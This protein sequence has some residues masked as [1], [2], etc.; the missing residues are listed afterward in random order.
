MGRKK[1]Y[2]YDDIARELKDYPGDLRQYCIE[3]GYNYSSIRQTIR[4]DKNTKNIL[5][6][7]KQDGYRETIV[8]QSFNLGK[9][10]AK[11]ITALQAKQ[12]ESVEHVQGSMDLI[13]EFNHGILITTLNLLHHKNEEMKNVTKP[14]KQ[15][16]LILYNLI[17]TLK[18]QFEIVKDSAL[19]VSRLSSAT[20]NLA[21][22][23]QENIEIKREMYKR[24]QQYTDQAENLLSRY[25]YKMYDDG[26]EIGYV[27]KDKDGS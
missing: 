26:R 9:S 27:G 23:L 4:G 17:G 14:T 10:E 18:Q 3:K 8:R 16:T 15:D 24:I 11:T 25:G 12:L 2:N 22:L 6:M 20:K 21:T 1:K 13:A 7:A 19:V 5:V